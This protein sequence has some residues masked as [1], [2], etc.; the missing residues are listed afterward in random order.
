MLSI[1]YILRFFIVLSTVSPFV[2]S[3]LFPVFLQVYRQLENQLDII[4]YDIIY[5][6]ISNIIGA[7]VK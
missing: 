4:S 7:V 6:T 2:Y 1:V 3:C 5:H